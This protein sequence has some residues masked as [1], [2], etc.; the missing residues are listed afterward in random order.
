MPLL[1]TVYFGLTRRRPVSG[2]LYGATIGLIQDSLSSHPIGMFGIAKTLVGY[3]SATAALRFDIEN[4]I[5]R[6]VSALLFY[7]GHQSLYWIM[8]RAL[9]GSV[10][11]VSVA[12]AL[13]QGVLNG[14]VAVPLFHLL[15]KLKETG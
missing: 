13:L 14:A 12:Q 3:L 6:F 8:E 11:E 4:P 10:V 15:D 9:L 5:A 2:L 1:V 7:L